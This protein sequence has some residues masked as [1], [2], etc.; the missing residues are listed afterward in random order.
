MLP[1]GHVEFTWGTL[2][3]LQY[4]GIFEDVDYR[5]MA[6]AAV[7]PDLIDKPL[8]VFVFPK[9]NAALLFSHTFVLHALVWAMVLWRGKK[10]IPYALAFSGH[11]L[12][13]RMWGFTQTFL[14]PF[15][16]RQFHQWRHVGSPDAF[17]RA[18]AE[19]VRTEPKL[20]AFELAGLGL[21]GWLIW[22][23]KLYQRKRLWRLILRGKVSLSDDNE[24]RMTRMD[25]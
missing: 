7:A 23:R 5:G 20:A 12:A 19:I 15:R 22:D 1:F 17:L 8:A 10:W 21:L 4:A 18:Y 3:A 11:M 24:S 16:G 25:K 9:A 6:L 2:N 13:D 14:W